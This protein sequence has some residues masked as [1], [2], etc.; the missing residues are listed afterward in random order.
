MALE[1]AIRYLTEALPGF[2]A[3]NAHG[4]AKD[5]LYLI[6]STIFENSPEVWSKM[7]SKNDLLSLFQALLYN[8]LDEISERN[9]Y[10]ARFKKKIT[11]FP[12]NVTCN[13]ANVL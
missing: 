2:E 1:I 6:V 10:A 7:S 3:L 9:V 12:I 13:L 4:R 5:V 11:D 8:T